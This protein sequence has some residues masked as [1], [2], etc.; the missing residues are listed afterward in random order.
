MP[1]AK[2]WPSRAGAGH[3]PGSPERMALSLLLLGL[4]LCILWLSLRASLGLGTSAPASSLAL[5]AAFT[6]SSGVRSSHAPPADA[7]TGPCPPSALLDR[8]SAVKHL[9]RPAVPTQLG[10]FPS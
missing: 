7:T 4:S 6:G 9:L 3:D 2:V 1:W 8:Q 5:S 10:V